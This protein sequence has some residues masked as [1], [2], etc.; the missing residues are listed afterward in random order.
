MPAEKD[1]NS[2]I[3]QS[4]ECQIKKQQGS[5]AVDPRIPD[6]LRLTGNS[7]ETETLFTYDK[8]RINL[9]VLATNQKFG[10]PGRPKARERK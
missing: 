7:C 1:L 5:P 9:F 10:R 2:C 6:H 8:I 3:K 4:F